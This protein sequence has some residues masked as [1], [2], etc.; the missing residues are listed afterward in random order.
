[1]T[2]RYRSARPHAAL[3]AEDRRWEHL[4]DVFGRIE[5][6]SDALVT[7]EQNQFLLTDGTGNV[8]EG[9]RRG[10]GLYAQDTRHLSVYEFLLDGTP[11]LVLLS[12]ADSGFTQ[13]QV[14][15]NHRMVGNEG[16]L[17]GRCTV[18]L[19]RQ[20]ILNRTLEERLRVTN[21][22]THSVRVRPSYLFAADFADIF[23]VRGHRRHREGRMSPPEVTENS[24]SY[25]YLG[26][27]GIWRRTLIL[28][29]QAPKTLTEHSAT[30]ELD[31]A[32]RETVE[33]TF[34]VIAGEEPEASRGEGLDRLRAE[35][36]TWKQSF[37][38]IRTDN[39]VFNQVLDRSL[40]DLRMLW[41]RDEVGASFIAAGTPWFA[42]L[43]GRDSIITALQT[44]PYRPEIARQTL[45]LLARHQGQS[46]DPF[47]AEEPGKILHEARS[48]EMSLTGELPYQRYYGSVDSTPLF[49]ILAAEYFHWTTDHELIE[50]LR[51]AIEAGLRWLL[52]YGDRGS[53][54]RLSRLPQPR[55]SLSRPR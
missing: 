38:H 43:F 21:Y 28:F 27:D 20:R 45:A 12:T 14:L 37:A 48:D 2:G 9:G 6:I 25:R 8:P 30:F 49:L 22:N 10:L 42:T 41:S 52:D 40:T 1:M 47:R 36:E 33:I 46:V 24:I 11:P 50:N 35:Y 34:Q 7:R 18:E 54:L 23:E 3:N 19:S 13:E 55:C 53:G 29:D 16:E 15:G 39:E 32:A 31:L 51:P 17:I 4:P 5:D 26:S 44:L